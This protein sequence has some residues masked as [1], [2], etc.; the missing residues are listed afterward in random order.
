MKKN[1]LTVFNGCVD[2]HLEDLDYFET[3]ITK[4]YQKFSYG[5]NIIND[6]DLLDKIKKIDCIFENKKIK[7]IAIFKRNITKKDSSLID[8]CSHTAYNCDKYVAAISVDGPVLELHI[9]RNSNYKDIMDT[10]D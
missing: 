5:Y 1:K 9:T 8:E 10:F 6:V 7:F 4:H 3:L 2:S